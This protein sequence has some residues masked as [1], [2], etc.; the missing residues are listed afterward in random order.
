[1]LPSPYERINQNNI[2]FYAGGIIF[3][4]KNNSIDNGTVQ[5]TRQRSGD[6]LET[7]NMNKRLRIDRC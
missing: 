7:A 1:M 6:Q 2:Y 4:N 3:H 5:S